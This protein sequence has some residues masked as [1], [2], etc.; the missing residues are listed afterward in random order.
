MENRREIAY[1]LL[2]VT[3]GV[4][5]FFYGVGKLLQGIDT[6]ASGMVQRFE[7]SP[8]PAWL[9][10]LF[11][12]M[13]PFTEVILGT[14]LILGLFT[15]AAYLLTQLLLLA[16]TFGTVME[17]RPPTVAD[18]VNFALVV[19][20]LFFLMEYNRYS[21]DRVWRGEERGD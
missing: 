13:L 1:A 2:R 19:F 6:V 8:L 16:L 3:V 12:R 14:L 21:V 15:G 5:F 9:V 18:N 20:V 11:A 17:P 10:A 4:M 7:A